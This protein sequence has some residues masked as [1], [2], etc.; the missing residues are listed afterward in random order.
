VRRSRPRNGPVQR[1]R[2][3]TRGESMA[4]FN[5]H[6]ARKQKEVARKARHQEK[7][8]RRLAQ[9]SSPEEQSQETTAQQLGQ[10][11]APSPE[12]GT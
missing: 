3:D 11:P 8:Q 4:K 10:T 7:Q 6:Q 2:F 9:A 5:C 12:T 1:S